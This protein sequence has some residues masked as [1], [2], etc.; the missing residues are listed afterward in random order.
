MEEFDTQFP[1]NSKDA[2]LDYLPESLSEE[3]IFIIK[4]RLEGYTNK[5][6]S[7]Y[8]SSTKKE[9]SEKIRLIIQML[10]DANS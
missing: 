8:T 6:I 3:H 2:I 5:E 4:M 7:D 1:Y 9:I 10:R